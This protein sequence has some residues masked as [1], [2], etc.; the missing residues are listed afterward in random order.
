LPIV[1]LYCSFVRFKTMTMPVLYN[2]L[3]YKERTNIT[4]SLPWGQIQEIKCMLLVLLTHGL[5]LT[6]T[7]KSRYLQIIYY[8]SSATFTASFIP[9]PCSQPSHVYLLGEPTSLLV[10]ANIHPLLSVVCQQLSHPVL[11]LLPFHTPQ[12]KLQYLHRRHQ[13]VSNS[14]RPCLAQLR[15][16]GNAISYRI[17]YMR[18][19]TIM[20]IILFF[21]FNLFVLTLFG[22]ILRSV[23]L[24]SVP[25]LPTFRP[26]LRWFFEFYLRWETV[27]KISHNFLKTFIIF[28]GTRVPVSKF[29][30]LLKQKDIFRKNT[31][32]KYFN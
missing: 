4:V 23:L 8:N 5:F 28:P 15:Y 30:W 29:M 31:K 19:S 17:R 2:I 9:T 11:V 6:W 24:C 12:I 1:F 22:L 16:M 7:Q 32:T 25:F 13:Q 14:S 21:L 3:F 10:V 27:F 18:L 26:F 20:P